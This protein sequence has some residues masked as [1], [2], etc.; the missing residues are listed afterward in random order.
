M[1]GF[2]VPPPKK[3]TIPLLL[4]YVYGCFACNRLHAHHALG[5]QKRAS[6]P[7]EFQMVESHPG[8]TGI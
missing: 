3:K 8:D 6:G 2:R 5:S 7:P 1:S 4:F